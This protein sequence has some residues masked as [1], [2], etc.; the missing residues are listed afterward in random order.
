MKTATAT[1]I[2]DK[3]WMKTDNTFAVKIANIFQRQEL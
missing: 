1:I 2:L 3:R